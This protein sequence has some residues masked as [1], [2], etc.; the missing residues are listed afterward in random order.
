ML[1]RS[2][3]RLKELLNANSAEPAPFTQPQFKQHVAK[4]MREWAEIVRATG[5]KVD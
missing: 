1:F 5:L 2:Q 4:E 3:P